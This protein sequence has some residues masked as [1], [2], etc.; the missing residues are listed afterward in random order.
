MEKKISMRS[1]RN[2]RSI[3]LSDHILR[4]FKADPNYINKNLTVWRD[5]F[6]FYALFYMII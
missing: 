5:R 6:H 1:M 3:E 2:L 4:G